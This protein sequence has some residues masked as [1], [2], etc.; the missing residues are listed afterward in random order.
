MKPPVFLIW[1]IV[2][3]DRT[4]M[5][6]LP[7]IRDALDVPRKKTQNIMEAFDKNKKA[8]VSLIPI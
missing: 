2:L 1:Q 6:G 8:E 5:D 7:G 3:L 4:V